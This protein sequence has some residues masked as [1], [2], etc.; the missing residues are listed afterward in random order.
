VERGGGKYLQ[1]IY[2]ALPSNYEYSMTPSILALPSLLA[3]QF[4]D[5]GAPAA[6]QPSAAETV[7]S[8]LILF[9]GLAVIIAVGVLVYFVLYSSLARVPQQFRHMEPGQVF[10]L[11][12]PCFNIYWN[13][14]VFMKIP[15]SF[16]AYFNSIGRYD[17]GDCGEELGKWAAICMACGL[18]PC[19]GALIAPIGSILV[20]VLL[21]KFWGY[22]NQIPQGQPFSP[23]A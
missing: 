11:L 18:I 3:W 2:I 5:F 14:E 17:V 6:Q 7:I 22:R 19:L 1:T 21:V 13:F 16:R 23:A 4:D 15:R 9:I 8:L 20:L 12:I 10:L